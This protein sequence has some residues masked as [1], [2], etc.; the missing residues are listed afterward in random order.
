ME[1]MYTDEAPGLRGDDEWYGWS[2]VLFCRIR[3]F[4]GPC[5]EMTRTVGERAWFEKL[6]DG[7]RQ[8]VHLCRC[9][10]AL[11]ECS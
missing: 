2:N 7:C 3:F 10:F 1:C 8:N 5:F 11:S 4:L 9:V 6:V